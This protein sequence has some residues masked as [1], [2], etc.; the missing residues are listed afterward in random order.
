M[1]KEEQTGMN[2]TNMLDFRQQLRDKIGQQEYETQL[3]PYKANILRQHQDFPLL[4][5]IDVADKIVDALDAK[6][7]VDD[8]LKELAKALYVLAAVELQGEDFIHE[9]QKSV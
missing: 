2:I 9:L 1:T 8:D 4:D 3:E 5:V 6:P 7:G